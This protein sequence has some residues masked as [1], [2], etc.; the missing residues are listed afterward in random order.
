M[1]ERIPAVLAGLLAM[2]SVSVAGSGDTDAA[3]LRLFDARPKV[4]VVNGYSTS[5][6]WPGILQRKLDRY[7]G[8]RVLEV[9]PATRGGTPVAKWIDVLTGEPLPPYLKTVRPALAK[10]GARPVVVLAQQSLQWAFGPRTAGIRN[11]QDAERIRRGA[12]VLEKYARLLLRD[13]ADLVFIAMHIYKKPMEPEIGNERLALAGFLKRNLPGVAAGPDVWTPTSRLWPQA[14]ARDKVHPNRVG[15]E[16]MAQHWFECLLAHDGLAA[17]PWSRDEMRQATN[18]VS[19]AK[20][21]GGSP[22]AGLSP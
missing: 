20:E 22:N 16:V 3:A 13:G 18:S 8:K 7:S 11:A 1:L 5:F 2:G 19:A 14:F 21:R 4:L 12:D 10:A 17:P 15:A 6:H 9:V